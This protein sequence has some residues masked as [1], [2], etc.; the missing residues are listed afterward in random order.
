MD[1]FTREGVGEWHLVRKA[2]LLKEHLEWSQKLHE[3]INPDPSKA[4]AFYEVTLD[5][6]PE[7]LLDLD[8]PLSQQGAKVRDIANEVFTGNFVS[9][10]PTGM[11]IYSAIG[12]LLD[13]DEDYKGPTKNL[14]N[15][16]YGKL[17]SEN[18]YASTY[19]LDRGIPGS[20][21]LDQMSRMKG[22]GT[23]NFVI[24][25]EE[26]INVRTIDGNTVEQ[27]IEEALVP[28]NKYSRVGAI[29][30][31]NT[32]ASER[33]QQIARGEIKGEKM[34]KNDWK[35]VYLQ[36][37]R[38][39]Y[40]DKHL[41]GAQ[42]VSDLFKIPEKTTFFDL[43]MSAVKERSPEQWKKWMLMIRQKFVDKYAAIASLEGDVVKKMREEGKSERQILVRVMA[44]QSAAGAAYR[45]DRGR[46]ILQAAINVGIPILKAGRAT[47]EALE[48]DILDPKT[49][50]TRKGTG[51]FSQ[52]FRPLFRNHL[53]ENIYSDWVTL[54]T[55]YRERR[56]ANER[57]GDVTDKKTK[58]IIRKGLRQ[59]DEDTRDNLIAD[60][61]AALVDPAHAFHQKA[62]IIET[63]NKN[64]DKWNEGFVQFLVDTGVIDEDA[65][66]LW[67]KYNDYIPFY[68]QFDEDGTGEENVLINAVI[69][70][71]RKNNPG[72]PKVVMGSL[73]GAKPPVKAMEGSMPVIDPLA[74][75][76]HNS[77]AAITSGL[78]NDAAQKVMRDG[79]Y[80][81]MARKLGIKGQYNE[82][83]PPVYDREG[84][85]VSEEGGEPA[86]EWTIH[87]VR[88]NGQTV[89]YEIVDKLLH[90]SLENFTDG[91]LPYLSFVAAPST[92]LREMVTRSPDFMLAN[93]L[94]DTV[95]AW[96]TSGSSFTPVTDTFKHILSN[97][98]KSTSWNAL[99]NA[100]VNMGYD[101]GRDMVDARN[102][103]MKQ[104]KREGVLDD[105]SSGAWKMMSK[106]W[107]W[108]GDMTTK[109]D[110]AT[111]QAVY[112]DVFAR[113]KDEHGVDIAEA[114]AEFQAQEVINFGR[115]GNSTLARYLTAAVPFLN[116][117]IQGID[118]LY[119]AGT[120]R[121]SANMD[122]V[123]QQKSQLAFI[124]R[125]GMLASV[126][127]VYWMMVHDDD[128][129][130][131][132]R[133][134]VRQDNLILPNFGLTKGSIKI[135]KPFEVGF[136]AFT[137]PEMIAELTFGKQDLRQTTEA[138]K[139]G[140]MVTFEFNP[141]PQAIRPV[142]EAYI[143]RSFFT[144]RP[145]VPYFQQ[146]MKPELQA[147][148]Y[149]NTFALMLGELFNA[150]PS[151]IEHVLRGY[152]GTLGSYAL[153]AADAAVRPITDYPTRPDMPVDRMPMFRRFWQGENGGGKLAEFYD[154]REASE[155]ITNSIMSLR[156]K[157]RHEE[158]RDLME[159]N[160]GVMQTQ[161]ARKSIDR[162]LQ[163]LRRH[164][165]NIM[166]S[167]MTGPEKRN[168]QDKIKEIQ[169]RIL[170]DIEEI[171]READLPTDLPFPLSA[172]N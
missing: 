118:V 152:T 42:Q 108:A 106:I 3:L 105:P 89:Q 91:K 65:K 8:K 48:I 121:Y 83:N 117:R 146:G 126:A 77:L 172:F 143:N 169:K 45:S 93:L 98:E 20:M 72:I 135:P 148:D 95:S 137:I 99:T 144:G 162:A 38:H 158:A 63:V 132:A 134:E 171:R 113:L 100:G 128:E 46:G 107:D 81:G 54:R 49:G 145:I 27:E 73:T 124:A 79:M 111:R 67:T 1:P 41:P 37:P 71:A 2:D 109:T 136:I 167:K 120:G 114:E 30:R 74:S 7:D 39:S 57:R 52:I 92:L 104:W 29:P 165:K 147:G 130:R 4:P 62:N 155:E 26:K 61:E 168:A 86:A 53:G 34:S 25:D 66:E 97:Q 112:E 10:D 149:T 16:L 68:R 11:D 15:P 35:Q 116:A 55:A 5:V 94:R 80:V 58:A 78:K 21:F 56:F 22:E 31:I 125:M 150:S 43:F 103:V 87:E 47:V 59:L 163:R 123:V 60:Y 101:F 32:A 102:E 122:K 85:M 64:F 9:D 82:E 156:K 40:L 33:A 151:K 6:N 19:L 129:Y 141:V 164:E 14:L 13:T 70:V 51:G 18:H 88:E 170:R 166:Y 76:L 28:P 24:W 140:I 138:I 159:E 110:M 75:I 131:D 133:P 44:H 69:D 96:A 90:N 36:T 160:M 157:G 119:R 161:G 153:F 139:R 12:E 115:R 127:T 23:R 17:G 50:A 154:F 142:Y 84:N